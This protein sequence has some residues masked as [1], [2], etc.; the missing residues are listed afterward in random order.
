MLAE[1]QE[2]QGLKQ[3]DLWKNTEMFE[4]SKAQYISPVFGGR[5]SY[6]QKHEMYF[7]LDI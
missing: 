7:H 1:R 5:L 6:P 4:V 2:K 3:F